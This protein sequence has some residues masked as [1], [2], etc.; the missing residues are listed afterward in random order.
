MVVRCFQK[1]GAAM[2]TGRSPNYPSFPLSEALERLKRLY[3]GIHTRAAERE[4]VAQNLGYKG[5]SG[6]SLSLI[7]TLRRY[8]LLLPEGKGRL[9]VSDRAV[10]I[11]ELSRGATERAAAVKDA[12]FESALFSQL[13]A[14]FGE[15]L[16]KDETLKHYLIKKGFLPKAADEI[17]RIYRDN[18]ELVREETEAYSDPMTASANASIAR[19]PAALVTRPSGLAGLEMMER[20]VPE[21]SKVLRLNVGRDVEAHIVFNGP[22]T[23]EAIDKLAKLLE[24]QK[25]TFPTQAELDSPSDSKAE[26]EGLDTS[27]GLPSL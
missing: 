7:A 4:V 2:T 1:G 23:Q 22:V 24:I 13:Y 18:I 8:G 3:S 5:L 10:S 12:A 21:G 25:D 9:R 16:P 17:I 15:S 20:I 11:M 6:P 14:D 19:A 26:R 27:R